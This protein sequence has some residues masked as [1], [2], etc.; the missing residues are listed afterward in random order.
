MWVCEDTWNDNGN[1]GMC[2]WIDGLLF[3]WYSC[4][5]FTMTW[6]LFPHR[7]TYCWFCTEQYKVQCTH[8]HST[9]DPILPILI[10][11]DLGCFLDIVWK[12]LTFFSI[13]Q[14]HIHITPYVFRIRPFEVSVWF[15]ITLNFNQ[16]CHFLSRS[17][18]D[19]STNSPRCLRLSWKMCPLWSRFA[20]CCLVT[21]RRLSPNHT[22]PKTNIAP[23]NGW[24]AGR[25]I[26]R[27]HVS[28]LEG[29]NLGKFLG[30]I[31]CQRSMAD[32][33]NW[34]FLRRKLLVF[35]RARLFELTSGCIGCWYL[36]MM[37]PAD[38]W[39]S[40]VRVLTAVYHALSKFDWRNLGP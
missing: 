35:A 29:T 34:L 19:K 38:L 15:E 11:F 32:S 16:R 40:N 18:R 22:I 24:L 6:M 1:S 26:F 20:I 27:C 31:S 5:G 7:S 13:F 10:P 17:F 36:L 3:G 33:H 4:Q 30:R 37:E 12:H 25:P 8:A 14:T 9:H 39:G 23:E 28:L 21:Q 2:H